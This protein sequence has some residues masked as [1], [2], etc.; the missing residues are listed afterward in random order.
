MEVINVISLNAKGLNVPE[1]RLMLL[2]DVHCLK[3][4]VAFVQETHFRDKKLPILKNRSFPMDYHST[5]LT[6]KSQGSFYSF[7]KQ[8]AMVLHRVHYRPWRSIPVF[9]RHDLSKLPWQVSKSLMT[10]KMSS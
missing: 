10:T 2:Q 9:K 7:F 1:K 8:S 6:A 4:D 3:S 5:N